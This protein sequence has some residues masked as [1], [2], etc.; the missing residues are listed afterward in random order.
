MSDG[1]STVKNLSNAPEYSVSEVSGLLKARIEEDFAHV[2]I[3]GEISGFKRAA[4]GHMYFALKDDNA[5]IDG[6]CWRSSAG[7]LGLAPEDGMEVVAVGRITTY[8]GRSKYQII[9]DKMELAGEGALLKLLEDRKR[10]LAAE[11][12][13][14]E[15]NKQDLPFLPTVI[16]VVT[17]PT[18][19][20]IRDILHRLSDRFP[21]HVLVWPVLVQGDGAADQIAKAIHG[22]N[23][24][25]GISSPARPDLLIVARGGGSL[26]DLWAFNEEPV[27]RAAYESDIPLISAVGHETDWTLIDL[28]ADVRAPTPTAAAEMAVP[29]RLDVLARVSEDGA[30]LA[31][32]MARRIDT[33]K[34]DVGASVRGLPNLSRLLDDSRQRLDDWSE[35]LGNALQTGL[36][37]RR[38]RLPTRIPK[39][40]GILKEASLRLQVNADN[41]GRAVRA[42]LDTKRRD[43]ETLGKLLESYSYQRVLERGFALVSKPD[44]TPVTKTKA[45]KAGD[46][47]VLT[48]QDGKAAA[49]VTVGSNASI[50][51]KPAKKTKTKK[52][53]SRQ[54]ELL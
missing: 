52:S 15:D 7:R 2:R 1:Q 44:G 23:A 53:D 29:V 26:E 19:S 11:G 32:A 33:A 17:S 3:R 25:D 8:A 49:R 51:K 31:S 24:F 46:D 27:V 28:A 21:R 41:L 36:T 14:D 16:G 9:V 4:S 42:P 34:R 10:K 40:D 50:A 38:D 30:R 5:L 48:L 54:G 18:G 37:R 13:F 39:P 35:R 47:V 6:V 20:V 43:V 22:F 45:L 12:L